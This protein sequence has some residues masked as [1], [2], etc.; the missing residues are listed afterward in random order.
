MRG[1]A[2]KM[3]LW[4]G[5]DPNIEYLPW[6]EWCEVIK[7][8]GFIAS[9]ENHVRHSDNYSIEKARRLIDYQPRYTIFQAM[10]EGVTSMIDRKLIRVS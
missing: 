3:F 1:I 10:C 5:R 7:D 6:K 2:E 4:F 9:T 8:P